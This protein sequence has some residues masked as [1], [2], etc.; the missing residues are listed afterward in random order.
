MNISDRFGGDY[1]VDGVERPMANIHTTGS[2]PK[3]TLQTMSL[4]LSS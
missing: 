2:D 3:V 4:L 1:E